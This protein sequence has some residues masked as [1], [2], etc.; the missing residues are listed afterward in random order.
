M[1]LPTLN[2][3]MASVDAVRAI[4]RQWAADT[5]ASVAAGGPFGICNGDECEEIFTAMGIPVLAINYWN[6]LILAQGKRDR[7]TALLHEAG[8]PGEHFFGFALAASLSP[9]D[10]PWGGLPNPS[11]I[12]ASTRNEMETRV[13][14]LWAERLG[15]PSMVM[16]FSFPSPPFRPLPRDWWARLYDQWEMMVDADRLD[17]RVGL[18]R[19]FIARTEAL[20]GRRFDDAVLAEAMA[21]INVQMERW[22]E[23][24]AMIAAAP[25]CPVHI[26]D[27]ISIYQ[28]M[29]HRGTERGI[30]L[31]REYCDEVAQRVAEGFA[32]YP[33][34]RLRLY[35]SVQVP[36]WHAAIEERYGAVAVC[37]SYTNIPDLYRRTFDPA[38][39]LRALAAR[40][41]ML[42]D[43]GPYRIIDVASRHRCDAAIVVEQAMGNGPSRQQQI[44]EEAGIPY[45]AIPR[46]ADDAEIRAM[47]GTFIET[48]LNGKPL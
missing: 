25:Q 13:C 21:R 40:H 14:E 47:I 37:C 38:D 32:A 46:A 2:R 39:P 23:A 31:I 6:Y 7:M 4:Q 33:D 17:Y 44:V 22:A 41:M 28:A 12:A 20:T 16:D 1:T 35:Y 45:L 42:F 24:Q 36:P 48:R 10:A 9:E 29:W 34:E 26:R 30:E 27:Q 15:C 3:R 18:E 19:R 5:R 8:Y 11:I 43:W